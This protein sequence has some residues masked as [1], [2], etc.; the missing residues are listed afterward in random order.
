MENQILLSQLDP[1][2]LKELI[3]STMREVLDSQP[4]PQPEKFHTRLEVCERL[5][6]SLVTFHEYQK[7]GIIRSQRFGRRVLVSET[8]LQAAL[9]EIPTRNRCR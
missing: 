5:H 3:R 9:K 2:S 6:I 1:A 7:A 8:D 4:P